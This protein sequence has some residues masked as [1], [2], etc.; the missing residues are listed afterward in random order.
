LKR[1]K[2]IYKGADHGKPIMVCGTSKTFTSLRTVE[3]LTGG[4][5]L[6]LFLAPSILLIGQT[7]WEWSNDANKESPL[8]AAG[9]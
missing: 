7:L 4:K 6:V 5:G 8:Q 2:A 1:R 9:Y 3:N